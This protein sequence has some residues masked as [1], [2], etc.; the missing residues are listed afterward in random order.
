[1]SSLLPI[2]LPVA[3]AALPPV[4]QKA[5]AGFFPAAADGATTLVNSFHSL[6]KQS[7]AALNNDPEPE[8]GPSDRALKN[9]QESSTFLASA[10]PAP[11]APVE[12]QPLPF[13]LSLNIFG[14]V[15]DPKNLPSE[16]PVNG[17]SQASQQDSPAAAPVTPSAVPVAD[18]KPQ[19]LSPLPIAAPKPQTLSALPATAVRQQNPRPSAPQIQSPAPVPVATSN[20]P[21]L[22]SVSVSNTKAALPQEQETSGG[23]DFDATHQTQMPAA[24]QPPASTFAANAAPVPT[25]PTVPVTI[26]DSVTPAAP[27]TPRTE[28]SREL[29]PAASQTNN[30]SPAPATPMMIVPSALAPLA[31]APAAAN[32]LAPQAAKPESMPT[33]S[34][35]EA[36]NEQAHLRAVPQSEAAP[37]AVAPELAFALR[38]QPDSTPVASAPVNTTPAPEPA[39]SGANTAQ[40]A[41]PSTPETAQNTN[42]GQPATA[43]IKSTST[44]APAP[45]IQTAESAAGQNASQN[46]GSDQKN[47]SPR[48]SLAATATGSAASPTSAGQLSQ[49]VYAQPATSSPASSSPATAPSRAPQTVATTAS[50]SLAPAV[51][52]PK[53]GAASQISISVPAGDQQNVQVRLMDRAGEVHVTVRAPNEDLAGNLRSDLSSLT[54]K[55]N[56]SGFS[57]EAFAPSRG[58]E[59]SR[60]QRSADPQ[61]Q[62]G[63][64]RQT[65][66]RNQQQQSS[67]QNARGNRPAWLDEFENSMAN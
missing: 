17:D 35:V 56:Q 29:K 64:E 40:A 12:N 33:A 48:Q 26:N 59:F 50:T 4:T 27:L 31:P 21:S 8:A 41:M 34:P 5:S 37:K 3:S 47:D 19:T 23:D 39:L 13:K 52:A 51:S 30:S 44:T 11:V 7:S 49:T 2:A 6:L 20:N 57:T 63:A 45:A 61:Q 42:Q 43:P 60:D 62:S 67:Q 65:S 53:T 58:G 10:A 14:N 55:L 9:G 22:L 36:R 54:G 28:R 25:L 38:V 32:A 46:A 1:M 24:P 15:P 66:G 18:A 16:Q